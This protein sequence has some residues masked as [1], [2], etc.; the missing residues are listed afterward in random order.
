[1]SEQS[2]FIAALEKE[3]AAEQAAYLDQACAGDVLLRQRIERLLQAHKPGDSFLER[4][5]VG[6]GRTVNFEPITERPGTVIGPYK[7]IVIC[8][9]C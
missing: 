1:M 8:R 3:D 5:P 4:G 9:A 6:L 2:I 7:L